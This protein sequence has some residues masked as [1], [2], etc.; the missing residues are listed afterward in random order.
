[1]RVWRAERVLA[2]AEACAIEHVPK[3][4]PS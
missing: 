4:S 3:P 1:V 2:I